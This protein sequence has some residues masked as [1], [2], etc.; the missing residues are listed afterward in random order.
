MSGITIH[1][2]DYHQN[3]AC[4]L[5]SRWYIGMHCHNFVNDAIYMSGKHEFADSDKT[6]NSDFKG[7]GVI[8][9][10]KCLE[11]LIVY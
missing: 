3:D 8:S 2:I 9:C 6:L 10:K 5:V 1:N 11:N 4:Q 7:L